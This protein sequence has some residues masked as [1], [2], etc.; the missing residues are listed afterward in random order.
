MVTTTFQIDAMLMRK[1]LGHATVLSRSASRKIVLLLDF[2][3][4]E[5]EYWPTD[6]FTGDFFA[7]HVDFYLFSC[8]HARLFNF[9]VRI[10]I[11]TCLPLVKD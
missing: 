9:T 8:E 1:L 10:A 3:F 4:A 6:V 11:Q 2:S 7:K 5:M